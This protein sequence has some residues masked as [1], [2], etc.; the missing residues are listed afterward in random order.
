MPILSVVP[1]RQALCKDKDFA[2]LAV[3][4]GAATKLV[5]L[6][7]NPGWITL[8]GKG[9]AALALKNIGHHQR[10]IGELRMLVFL[11]PPVA[12]PRL[13]CTFQSVS[14]ELG[15]PVATGGA[16]ADSKKTEAERNNMEEAIRK[17]L[18]ATSAGPAA[19]MLE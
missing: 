17:I 3:C 16:G 10:A 7:K 6:L 13:T 14:V 15:L 11:T 8:K 12:F 1:R 19:M 4:A 5:A 2:Q 18:I 9:L